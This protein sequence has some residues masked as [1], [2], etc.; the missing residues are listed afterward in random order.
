V[1]DPLFI[2]EGHEVSVGANVPLQPKKMQIIALLAGQV[3]IGS[4]QAALALAP[5]QFCL[6]PA[7]LAR[8][9]L[10]AETPATFLRVEV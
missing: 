10:R 8:V 1:R 9:M 5:G 4:D 6:I 2:V 3:Q 7:S